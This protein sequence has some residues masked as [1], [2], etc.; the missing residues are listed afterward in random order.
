MADDGIGA[1][2]GLWLLFVGHVYLTVFEAFGDAVGG[3]FA[4]AERRVTLKTVLEV[5]DAA[6]IACR[7]S[8]ATSELAGHVCRRRYDLSLYVFESLFHDSTVSASDSCGREKSRP[9]SRL[10]LA[11][12]RPHVC[13]LSLFWLS[14][15]LE[16]KVNC[17]LVRK[18]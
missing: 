2:R 8:C 14:M 13:R 11:G 6:R 3:S 9:V 15:C 10:V 16:T 5:G 4:L 17:I 18:V 12:R 1:R 7:A